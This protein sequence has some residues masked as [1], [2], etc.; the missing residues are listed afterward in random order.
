MENPLT[1]TGN[2]FF[3]GHSAGRPSLPWL[4][5]LHFHRIKSKSDKPTVNF[6]MDYVP[7]SDNAA[8]QFIDS[9]TV[10]TEY[11]RTAAKAQQYKGGMYWKMEGQY[12][13]LVKTQPDNRQTRMGKRSPENERIYADFMHRKKQ[14]EDRLKSLKAALADAERLN[15]ALR[16]GRTPST[17]IAVLQALHEARLYEH[18][19][20]VG[21]HALYAYEAAAGVRIQQGALA[22]MD[23][24]LLWDARKRVQFMTTMNSQGDTMLDVLR[25][26]DKTFQRKESQLETAINDKGFE[27]DFLRRQPVGD[28]PHPFRFSADEDDLWPIQAE[29]AAVLTQAPVFEQVVVS[30]TGQMAMMRTIAPQSF[31]AFKIWMAEDAKR[32]DPAKRR[33]DKRQAEIVQG[34]LINGLLSSPS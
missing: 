28:D 4:T 16:V 8:R 7:L 12:E 13:Y 19:T 6:H 24:D 18:F 22:T 10:F 23:V 29:R 27:V 3:V 20:V 32:R 26:A 30:A 34:L 21:T 33:R 5:Q 11:T 25:R 1:F 15:K 31:V 17:V 14:I 9:A 2:G